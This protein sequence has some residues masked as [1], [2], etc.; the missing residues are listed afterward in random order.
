MTKPK[1][2][3][4]TAEVPAAVVS[5][6]TRLAYAAG[7]SRSALIRKAISDLIERQAASP[8]DRSSRCVPTPTMAT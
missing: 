4:L 5:R 8:P 6:L 3:M 7:Q 1:K 2:V